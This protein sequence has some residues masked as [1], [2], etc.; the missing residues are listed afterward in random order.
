M[1]S[2]SSYRTQGFQKPDPQPISSARTIGLSGDSVHSIPSADSAYPREQ[3]PARGLYTT[4]FDHD[5]FV[6]RAE[7]I[8][9][10]RRC[11]GCGFSSKGLQASLTIRRTASPDLSAAKGTVVPKP[12]KNKS[13]KDRV[14]FTENFLP[15]GSL[16]E[17]QFQT[18]I[19]SQSTN[20]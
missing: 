15:I 18:N 10:E 3:S 7:M 11:H 8:G 12:S 19:P 17:K 2:S 14:N 1:R 6:V 13:V 9:L 20:H 4:T 16:S 5:C